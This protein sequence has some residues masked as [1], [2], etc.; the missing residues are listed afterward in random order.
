MKW[1][2]IELAPKYSR[3]SGRE[4]LLRWGNEDGREY[5]AFG[6]WEDERYAKKPKPHWA[7]HPF[8]TR[9]SKNNE[10]THF[11]IIEGPAAQAIKDQNYDT[12]IK[13]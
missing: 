1:Q 7:G 5:I 9:Y 6:W 12:E 8:G 2:P 11:L 10:P 3:Y 4:M 13:Q